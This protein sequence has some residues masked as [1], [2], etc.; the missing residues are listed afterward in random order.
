MVVTFG[1]NSAAYFLDLLTKP[2]TAEIIVMVAQIPQV[3][4]PHAAR[5][6]V[7]ETS[8]VWVDYSAG[9]KGGRR[10]MVLNCQ[11][12]STPLTIKLTE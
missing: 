9:S 11:A 12:I 1:S 10:A 6:E 4:G 3:I 5:P 7:S 2:D 8:Q